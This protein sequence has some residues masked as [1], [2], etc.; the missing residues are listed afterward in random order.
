MT[1]DTIHNIIFLYIIPWRKII[2]CVTRRLPWA[3]PPRAAAQLPA[4][5]R[6]FSLQDIIMA[7]GGVVS[8]TPAYNLRRL[9]S[10]ILSGIAHHHQTTFRSYIDHLIRSRCYNL[11]INVFTMFN[12]IHKVG[13]PYM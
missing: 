11:Q 1:I 13:S 8:T 3:A 7:A 2:L 4:H 6:H 12:F 10:V 9:V 5:S